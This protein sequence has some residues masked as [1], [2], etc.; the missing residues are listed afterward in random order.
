MALSNASF[1]P[2][3]TGKCP[4]PAASLSR[5]KPD[6]FACPHVDVRLEHVRQG[7]ARFRIGAIRR[8]DQIVLA[9]AVGA[10]D[11]GVELEDDAQFTR[12][13]LKDR[14]QAFAADATEAVAR[15]A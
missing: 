14:Q 11:F 8:D 3:P 1:V 15:R 5:A 6:V 2:D 4:V 13:I 9:V 10:L 7:A 12:A